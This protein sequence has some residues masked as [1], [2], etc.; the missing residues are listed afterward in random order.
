MKRELI[1]LIGLVVLIATA[2]AFLMFGRAREVSLRGPGRS[3]FEDFDRASNESTGGGPRR[4]SRPPRD[5]APLL[6]PVRDSHGR[7][8]EP[9][10]SRDDFGRLQGGILV[11]V[12]GTEAEAL[13]GAT[14]CL[15]EFFPGPASGQRG[16]EL[17]RRESDAQGEARFPAL[18][19]GPA[20]ALVVRHPAFRRFQSTGLRL[21]PGRFLI[22]EVDLGPGIALGGRVL[23]ETDQSPIAGAEVTVWDL[24][25]GGADPEGEIEASGATDGAGRF[26]IER[27][28]SGP[29][30][31]VASYPGQGS[32]ARPWLVLE[33]KL[34]EIELKLG[35]GAAMSGRVLDPEGRP[36]RGASVRARP[37]VGQTGDAAGG[38]YPETTTDERGVWV[39]EGLRQGQYFLRASKRGHAEGNFSRPGEPRRTSMANA[40]AGEMGID[41][42]LGQGPVVRGRVIDGETGE[43]LGAFDLYGNG[44]KD[45]VALEARD[46]QRVVDAEGRFEYAVPVVGSQARFIWLHARAPGYAGGSVLVDF[47]LRGNGIGELTGLREGVEIVM[48]KG[49]GLAGRVVDPA[50]RP[51]PG[52]SIVARRLRDP[53]AVPNSP[54]INQLGPE[55]YVI[56]GRAHGD[57][58]GRFLVANLGAGRYRVEFEHPEFA[59]AIFADEVEFEGHGEMDIGT[60]TL[61]R[62]GRVTG[63]VVD[64]DGQ[65]E[66]GARVALYATDRRLGARFEQRCSFGGG[67]DFSRV[68]AGEYRLVV[69]ERDGLDT[70][71]AWYQELKKR[72][73]TEYPI[74]VE[75]GAERDYRLDG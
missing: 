47:S 60:T 3:P 69:I 25:A 8:L 71:S 24:S 48:L 50:G 56:A 15:H 43:P 22:Q 10:A 40:V 23:T 18:E 62:G 2:A 13:S 55:S 6:P 5:E 14:V 17:A 12:R 75:D 52:C 19:V 32:A 65:P 33:A 64:Q 67:F 58:E 34:T 21:E 59:P 36:I 42:Y 41:L 70:R 68:P 54:L 73:P 49:G 27:L 72:R 44:A 74:V 53:A 9:I 51:L 46:R 57:E 61:R 4:G 1:F 20:Y 39:I 38:Y 26:L 37:V 16:E 45:P 28:S 31:V 11:V 35:Q 29:K 66:E 63:Q 7:E 30:R